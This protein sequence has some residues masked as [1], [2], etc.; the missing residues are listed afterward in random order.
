MTVPLAYEPEDFSALLIADIYHT[1]R[2]TADED[3]LA[4]RGAY[5]AGLWGPFLWSG[6]QAI[7]K[8][9]KNILLLAGRSTKPFQH[10]LTTLLTAARESVP[11]LRQLEAVDE[12]F[13]GHLSTHGQNRYLTHH[14]VKDKWDL[15]LLDRL[16]RRL[17]M[18]CDVGAWIAA[19]SQQPLIS[20]ALPSSPKE[21]WRHVCAHSVPNGYLEKVLAR[22]TLPSQRTILVWQNAMYCSRPTRLLRVRSISWNCKVPRAGL[23]RRQQKWLADRVR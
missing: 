4:A 15:F 12:A 11:A 3:Y 7:E 5:K 10:D 19:E 23:N 14:R 20:Q 6:L 8:Y 22:K 2:D 1:W 21:L 9:F 16:T 18:Y 13:V 17:R